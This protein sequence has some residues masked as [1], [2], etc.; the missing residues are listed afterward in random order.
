VIFLVFFILLAIGLG[1]WGY[2]GYSGQDK[3]KTE[4]KA[5]EDSKAAANLGE[6]VARYRAQLTNVAQ[7]L[8]MDPEDQKDFQANH[9]AYLKNEFDKDVINKPMI[10]KMLDKYKADGVWDDPG[11]KFTTTY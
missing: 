10:A 8:D 11:K 1:V 4:R 5:A 7:G 2:Y 3:L 9:D 6:R